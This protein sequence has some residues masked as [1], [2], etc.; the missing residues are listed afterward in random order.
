MFLVQELATDGEP[1]GN[2]CQIIGRPM[3]QD[4]VQ[5]KKHEIV[6]NASAYQLANNERSD[7]VK[8]VQLFDTVDPN[9]NIAAGEFK[10][11][12]TFGYAIGS[13]HLMEHTQD[14]LL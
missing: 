6:S 8:S 13:Q 7:V 1:P 9:F 5:L 3:T 2:K 11:L 14:I 10:P 4:I 12:S